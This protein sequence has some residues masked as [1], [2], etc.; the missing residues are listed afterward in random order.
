MPPQ[1]KI[2]RRAF[3]LTAGAGM[4][5]TAVPLAALP[6]ASAGERP[7]TTV[8]PRR[9]AAGDT[10]G[11]INPAGATFARSDLSLVIETLAA[12]GL[13]ARPGEHVLDRYGYLAGTD[14]ARASD[15]NAMFADDAVKAI[16]AVR[17]GWG[18]NRILPL[19]DYDAIRSHP[20][21][22]MGYS[23]I[24]SLLVAVYA[25]SGM[26]TFHG[27]VGTSTWNQFSLGYFRRVVME[28][29]AATF[30]NPTSPGDNLVQ[31]RD[32]I[33]VITP[34]T[35]RGVLVGG[36]L[37]VL[38][39]MIGSTYLPSWKNVLLFLEDDNEPVYRIDRMLTQLRLAGVLEQLSG[40]VFGKCTNCGPGEG[41]GSLTLEEVFADH[42]APLR[43][44]AFSG[45]MIGH[46]ENKFT[47]PIG[48]EADMDAD[49][50]TLTMRERA[51]E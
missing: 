43:I 17:G 16:L 36:N 31:T 44:P 11:L 48:I 6:R 10:V 12:L 18:C 46:I 39:A 37:S 23:D 13:T 49:N 2:P 35:A 47:I 24:T 45:A 26:V 30:R 22:L 7:V 33:D 3:L 51:V 28:G 4:L 40:F 19:L 8:K 1:W 42:I 50:G 34:G 20:K 29:E 25:R 21:V 38:A 32:R 9:L 15:L 5:G 27:P 41:Y 14:A